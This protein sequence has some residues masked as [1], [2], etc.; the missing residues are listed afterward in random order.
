MFIGG[1]AGSTAGGLKVSRIMIMGKSS[2]L[3]AKKML[4]PRA[5][6]TVRIDGKPISDDLIHSTSR[7]FALYVLIF[8]ISIILVSF[9]K[10]FSGTNGILSGISSVVTT[11]NNVGPGFGT[12]GPTSNFAGLTIFSK[13]ILSIDM[14]VG[15]LEILPILLIFY[16]KAWRSI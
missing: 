1:S 11:L 3:S 6:S 7:Y 13:I 9:D 8:V 5:V 16:P 2:M 15:R 12:V 10:S 14:L 4:S